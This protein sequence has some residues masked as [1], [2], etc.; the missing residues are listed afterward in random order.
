MKSPSNYV[1]Y[2]FLLQLILVVV[3]YI[4]KKCIMKVCCYLHTT[5]KDLLSLVHYYYYWWL[6]IVS[7]DVNKSWVWVEVRGSATSLP[8]LAMHSLLISTCLH[9]SWL[10]GKPLDVSLTQCG[11]LLTLT[12]QILTFFSAKHFSSC[13]KK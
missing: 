1:S 11:R 6:S 2:I 10:L 9:M 5:F 13:V 8:Y 12:K 7:V 4:C 3:L